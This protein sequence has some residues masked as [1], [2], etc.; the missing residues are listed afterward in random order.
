M[1][2]SKAALIR[3]SAAGIAICA[4]IPVGVAMAS[5]S[6]AAVVKWQSVGDLT[7]TDRSSA[8]TLTCA[9]STATMAPTNTGADPVGYV[10]S[11]SFSQ[12][13]AN[14]GLGAVPVDLTAR[15]LDW[16]VNG[17]P[18]VRTVGETSGGHGISVGVVGPFGCSGDVDGTGANTHTGFVH[19]VF[20]RVD[21]GLGVVLSGGNLHVYANNNCNVSNGD[22]VSF[23]VS[24][25]L[26]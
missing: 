10:D 21:D 9:A 26:S 20:R 14:D 8:V 13:T 6:A 18:G 15:G 22:A 4:V 7:F 5:G 25:R 24:Y 12:C 3:A 19:L 17:G 11:I 16:P 23:S 2:M 1:R